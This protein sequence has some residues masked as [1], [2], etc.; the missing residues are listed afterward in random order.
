MSD[1]VGKF[2]RFKDQDRYRN[3]IAQVLRWQDGEKFY[4]ASDHFG[5]YFHPDDFY[6]I[7]VD[8][9]PYWAYPDWHEFVGGP[10]GLKKGDVIRYGTREYVVGEVIEAEP[11]EDDRFLTVKAE[12][13]IGF[14]DYEYVQ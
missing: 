3:V 14:P 5:L 13:I 1:L 9:R 7:E 12:L 4:L 8:E 6:V 11:G 10:G 2:V